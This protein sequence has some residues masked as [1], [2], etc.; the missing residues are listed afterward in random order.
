MNAPPA[1]IAKLKVDHRGYPVP[2]FVQW[3]DGKPDHRIVDPNKIPLA[4]KYQRCWICGESLG[5]YKTFVLGPM[6]VVNRTVSE[7]PSHLDCAQF[8]VATCPFLSIPEKHRRARNLPENVRDAVG[9]HIHR[10]PGVM[11]LWTTFHYSVFRVQG[12]VLFKPG[13]PQTVTWHAEGRAATRDEVLASFEEG[14][15]LLLEFA[16][17]DGPQSVE[18]LKLLRERALTYL[19]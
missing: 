13:E 18:D 14:Y 11:A 16:E 2:W 10:N 8:A 17:R 7:P 5:K 3:I 12:G 15:P 4:V 6:C 1:R 19:P 9:N